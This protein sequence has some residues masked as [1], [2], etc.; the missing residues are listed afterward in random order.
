MDCRNRRTPCARFLIKSSSK[1]LIFRRLCAEQKDEPGLNSWDLSY[2]RH[3]E[4]PHFKDLEELCKVKYMSLH[5]TDQDG[6]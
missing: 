6:Q 4:H 5:F 1:K 2:F 3:P